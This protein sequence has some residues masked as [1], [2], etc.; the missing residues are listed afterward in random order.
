MTLLVF[1]QSGQLAQE[2]Q[3][4]RP[5]ISLGRD[6]AELSDPQACAATIA[7]HAPSAVINAAAYTG[8]D[9]AEADEARATRINGDA[10][11]AM[12]RACAQL[13]IPF[14][15]LSTDYVFSGTGDRPW[16]PNDPTLPQNAYGRSKR[17]GEQ[18]VTNAGGSYAV[19]RTSWVFSSHGSNFVKT[20]LRLA[21]T[22]D[23]LGIVS[24]QIGGPTP[25]RDL[26]AACMRIADQLKDQ[27]SQSGIYHFSGAPDTSWLEFAKEIFDQ[28]G[29]KTS[30]RPVKTKD[31]ATPAQRP[32]NSRLDCSAT[33]SV[34]GITRPDW[35]ASLRT[36]LIELGAVSSEREN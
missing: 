29:L 5:V 7:Q 9:A 13:R 25:A 28:A 32:L 3:N 20:M 31:Y 2:L 23:D 22:R 16:T 34:F 27:P 36:V 33:E 21:Q 19:I 6:L 4:Q 15:H 35:R 18:G 24:D 1:G 12:A 14:V 30:V 11:A 8:V 26:A 17:A 10:P